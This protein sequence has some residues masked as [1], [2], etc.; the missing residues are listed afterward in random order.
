MTPRAVAIQ[1]TALLTCGIGLA[2]FDSPAAARRLMFATLIYLP[3]LFSLM[4]VG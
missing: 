4:A 2:L 1:G 3:R